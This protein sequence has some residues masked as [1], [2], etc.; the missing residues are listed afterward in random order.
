MPAFC[1]RPT[2]DVVLSR[3]E[4]QR[5]R[6][7]RLEQR[8]GDL[9][10]SRLAAQRASDKARAEEFFGQ[11]APRTVEIEIPTWMKKGAE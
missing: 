11:R 1:S 4:I 7:R 10:T 2:E 9:V 6:N 8:Q 3:I 5:A